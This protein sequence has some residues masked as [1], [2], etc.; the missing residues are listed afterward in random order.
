MDAW[1]ELWLD[2]RQLK[3][4]APIMRARLGLAAAKGCDAV[5]PDNVDTYSNQ[6]GRA[7][8]YDDQRRY[9]LFLAREAHA[10]G[11]AIGLK[12]NLAQVKDLEPHFDFAVNEECYQWRECHMLTPFIEANKAV[13]STE[14]EASLAE[15]CPLAE[16]LNL[17]MIKKEYDLGTYREACR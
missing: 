10:R 14:Y 5:E 1:D 15:V 12:N 9:N 17:S 11:L 16:R 13:F 6:T 3:Q 8:S 2:I 4:L 7:L